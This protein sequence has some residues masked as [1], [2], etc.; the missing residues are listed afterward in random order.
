MKE[1][2]R[3]VLLKQLGV[4]SLNEIDL[5]EDRYMFRIMEK[6]KQSRAGHHIKPFEFMKYPTDEKLC[7][8]THFQ[9]YIKRTE[10]IHFSNS[11]LLISLI[12]PHGPIFTD[13]LVRWIKSVLVSAGIYAN[14]F[15]AHSTRVTS[16]SHLLKR[17]SQSQISLMQLDGKVKILFRSS[18]TDHKIIL[19]LKTVFQRLPIIHTQVAVVVILKCLSG[20]LFCFSLTSCYVMNHEEALVFQAYLIFLLNTEL[21]KREGEVTYAE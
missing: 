14:R 13:S 21:A 10:N 4:P 1:I 12:K 9:E 20:I 11:K 6:L 18:T 15:T 19:I 3:T 16:S 8:F 2:Y 17:I 5:L 7:I